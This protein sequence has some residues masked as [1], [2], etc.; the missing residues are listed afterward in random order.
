MDAAEEV[1][2]LNRIARNPPLFPIAQRLCHQLLEHRDGLVVEGM[3]EWWLD[4]I[5]EVIDNRTTDLE[6]PT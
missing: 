1:E 2:R 5:A 6:G 4:D 3:S